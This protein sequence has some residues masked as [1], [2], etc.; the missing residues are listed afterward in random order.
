MS[1]VVENRAEGD[2]DRLILARFFP[3]HGPGRVCVDVGAARPD[4]L[5]VSAL[6]RSRGWRVLAV[7]PNP[8]F[9]EMH[10]ARGHEVLPYA[11]G[12]RD[13]DDV[14]FEVV[15][16]HGVAYGNGEVS[17]ESYS[18]LGAK[19]GYTAIRTRQPDLT[20]TTIRVRL[21]RL[22]T[23]LAE[24]A[25]A[26][27]RVDLLTVDVE[28]WE[29]EVLRGFSLDRYRPRVVVLENLFESPAY[30]SY[31]DAH[32]YALW[33]RVTPN[34]VYV[35]RGCVPRGPFRWWLARGDARMRQPR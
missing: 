15:D 27:R 24:H 14:P 13:A 28:G 11:C 30:P 33:R 19:E 4:F 9:C 34:D 12:D 5:S 6:F 3:N 29:L 21:R 2:V 25:P 35:R 8:A 10:R 23:L 22:D 31:M 20:S 32:G 16:S 7:E 1:G 17:F 18:S 26:L